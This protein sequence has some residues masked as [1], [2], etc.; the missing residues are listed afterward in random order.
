MILK[1]KPLNEALYVLRQQH[2][3]LEAYNNHIGN[4]LTLDTKGHFVDEY[5]LM[6]TMVRCDLFLF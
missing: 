4:K 3:H 6:S 5:M 2:A 1:T